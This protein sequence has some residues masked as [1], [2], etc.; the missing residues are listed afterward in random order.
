[1]G[2]YHNHSVVEYKKELLQLQSRRRIQIFDAQIGPYRLLLFEH[3][4]GE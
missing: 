1:V 2:S 3:E 4:A